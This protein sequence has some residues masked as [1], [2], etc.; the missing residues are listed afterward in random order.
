MTPAGWLM[1]MLFWGIIIFLTVYSFVLLITTEN[2]P[3]P[4]SDDLTRKK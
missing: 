1:M 2:L 3:V 4:E